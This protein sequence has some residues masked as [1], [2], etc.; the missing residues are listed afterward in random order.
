M[1]SSSHN[2]F[3]DTSIDIAFSRLERTNEQEGKEMA[4]MFSHRVLLGNFIFIHHVS[5][6]NNFCLS[7]VPLL[8]WHR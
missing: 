6:T 7:L 5:H 2:A 8:A 4:K 1:K 3:L